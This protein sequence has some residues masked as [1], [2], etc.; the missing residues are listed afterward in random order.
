[1]GCR[2]EGAKGCLALLTEARRRTGTGTKVTGGDPFLIVSFLSL[3]LTISRSL[4]TFQTVMATSSSITLDDL[5][6]LEVDNHTLEQTHLSYPKPTALPPPE[7]PE[8]VEQP[9]RLLTDR[10]YIGNLHPS[11]DE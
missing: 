8:P 9:R 3:A 2:I 1:M 11:V 4:T 10:L 5:E 6:H 7:R